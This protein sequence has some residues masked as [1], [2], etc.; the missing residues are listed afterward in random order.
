VTPRSSPGSETPFCTVSIDVI[1]SW[2]VSIL[3]SVLHKQT[4]FRR[5]R[6]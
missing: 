5:K 4:A 1:T 3:H 6:R 2:H